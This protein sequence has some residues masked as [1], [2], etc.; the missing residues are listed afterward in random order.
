MNVYIDKSNIHGVGV[1][2]AKNFDINEFIFTVIRNHS[3]TPIGR[4]INHSYKPNCVLIKHRND[5]HVYSNKK[6][7]KYTELT[8]DYTFT[9]Y[10]IKKP[11]EYFP[12]LK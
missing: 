6:I 4:K 10:Y 11:W 2:A 12:R 3:I 7:D 9:P 5:F 8:V 1:F